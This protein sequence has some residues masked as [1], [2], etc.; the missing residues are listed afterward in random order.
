MRFRLGTDKT[1]KLQKSIISI[2][3]NV[4]VRD[5][6]INIISNQIK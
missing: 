5:R 3:N 2:L 1:I 6:Y 4:E